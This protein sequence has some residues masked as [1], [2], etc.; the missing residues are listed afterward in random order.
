MGGLW[1]S[2]VKSVKRHYK[3]V[4]RNQ[5][6]TYEKLN[7]LMIEIEAML[8]SRPITPMTN[9]A[10]DFEALTP[11]H[12]LIGHP[13]TT[14]PDPD[15]KHRSLTLHDSWMVISESKKLFFKR[16][17]EEYLTTLQRN[18]LKVNDKR[19]IKEETLVLLK[20]E[21]LPG[22]NWKRARVTKAIKGNDGLVRV[23]ELR[24]PSGGITSRAINKICPLPNQEDSNDNTPEELE[25]TTGESPSTSRV[26]GFS[27]KVN[28]F[29]NFI[30]T[31]FYLILI[32]PLILG[33]YHHEPIENHKS[34]VL[35]ELEGEVKVI[36]SHCNIIAFVNL[37]PY[38]HAYDGLF[39]SISFLNHTCEN[40]T[41][42]F[43]DSTSCKAS[44]ATLN[45]LYER[46]SHIHEIIFGNGRTKRRAP[47]GFFGPVFHDILGLTDEETAQKL[48][49]EINNNRA[50]EQTLLQLLRNQTIL[51]DATRNIVKENNILIQK[52]FEL[53]E[54]EVKAI[55]K[56]FNHDRYNQL[57]SKTTLI[58]LDFVTLQSA[59]KEA[60]TNAYSGSVNLIML[61]PKQFEDCVQT[62]RMHLPSDLTFPENNMLNLYKTIA[63]TSRSDSHRLIVHFKIP[64]VSTEDYE[65][66]VLYPFPTL[67]KNMLIGINVDNSFILVNKL[68][69]RYMLLNDI[70]NLACKNMKRYFLCPGSNVFHLNGVLTC[71]MDLFVNNRISDDCKIKLWPLKTVWI[72]LEAA[73]TWAYSSPFKEQVEIHS[74][75]QTFRLTLENQ[76]IITLDPGCYIR[77]WF[78]VVLG[79]W[80]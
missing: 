23:V 19:N 79:F 5:S 35:S 21:C 68:K 80:W 1:E 64:L 44:V 10:T 47:L 53:L 13:L 24:T 6:L 36:R 75:E 34:G 73:N 49:D 39:N 65:K 48:E 69:D 27:S 76:G 22:F 54:N 57:I 63:V 9:D 59:I 8:N 15:A 2:T 55:Q 18:Y 77:T 52:R 4:T 28:K 33:Q 12:F 45:H 26:K 16:F 71:E 72:S 61:K 41:T 67:H 66:V 17:A 58:F 37:D 42:E 46:S 38:W 11:G 62:L 51:H 70:S 50:N 32:L 74:R 7:T 40:A 43:Q 78:L 20:E 3:I 56:E 30:V 31:I 60:L 29:N 14:L 25:P